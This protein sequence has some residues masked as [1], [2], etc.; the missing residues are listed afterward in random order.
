MEGFPWEAAEE[1][2]R[3]VEEVFQELGR[4]VLPAVRVA[5]TARSAAITGAH[6]QS[7]SVVHADQSVPSEDIWTAVRALTTGL[8][9]AGSSCSCHKP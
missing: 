9:A 2:R 1:A 4:D 7:G 6:Q 3:G 8:R 5:R